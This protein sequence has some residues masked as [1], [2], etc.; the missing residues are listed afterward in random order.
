MMLGYNTYRSVSPLNEYPGVFHSI[1]M[2][3]RAKARAE[4]KSQLEAKRREAEEQ[5]LVSD[6]H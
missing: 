4:K 6:I 2:E 5:Q 3:E 1:A